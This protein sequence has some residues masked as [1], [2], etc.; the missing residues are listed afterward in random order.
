MAANSTAGSAGRRSHVFPGTAMAEAEEEVAAAVSAA[1]DL[2]RAH[3]S[4]RSDWDLRMHE[5]AARSGSEVR[6]HPER[7]FRCFSQPQD[8]HAELGQMSLGMNYDGQ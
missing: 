2:C 4:K 5:R 7:R 1:R 6:A 3:L 8:H